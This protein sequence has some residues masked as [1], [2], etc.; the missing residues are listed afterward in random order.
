MKLTH[1]LQTLAVVLFACAS[2]WGQAVSVSNVEGTVTDQTGAVVAN[3]AVTVVNKGTGAE[4]MATTDGNG[5]Y[6][7]AGL[8]PGV[9]S[10]KIES[11]GFASQ[12]AENV[13][14]NVGTTLTLN[15]S[16]KPAAAA[17]TVVISA[18]DAGLIETTR[19]DLGGV[20]NNREIENLPLN[21]RSLAGL[22]VLIPGARPTQS[23]D[24][25]KNRSAA[26]SVN[27]GGGRNINTTV[28]GG[29]NKDNTVGGIV[30]N[31]S[32]E[33]VQE[34]KLETQRFS[35][36]SGRS[37]GAALN[38]ITKSGSNEF[39]GSGFLFA[40][41]E[42]FNANDHISKVS[43]RPKADY[44]RQQF[45]GSFGGPI[46]KDRLFFFGVYERTRE[47][48]A[49]NVSQT[50][51]NE[52]QNAV[53]VGAKPILS[54]P[55][56]FRDNLWQVRI[57]GKLND[58][59]T[60][61][62]KWA[63]QTNN[64]LNDQANITD[65][66]S[67]NFTKNTLYQGT[68]GL[69]STIS[70]TLVNQFTFAYQYW[71]NLIDSNNFAP[72]LAF[73]GAG[74]T[75][76]TNPNI[77]QQSIQKK[78]QLKEDMFLTAGSHGLK[79]GID[80]VAI[81]K[82]GGF[83]RTPPTPNLTFLDNPSV[84]VT[85]KTK[86]PQGFATP[87]AVSVLT[88]AS[89]DPNFDYHNTS[90]FSTYFQDDWKARPNLTLNLGVR[91]DL[92]I[93]FLPPLLNNRTY[94]ILKQINHPITR[95]ALGN[96][97]NNV[98]P[99]VGFAWDIKG[100]SKNVIRG[101]YGIYY[102]QVFQNI[103]L[104]AQQ[105]TNDT[106]F[107][108]VLSLT[109]TGATPQTNNDP[110]LR[111]FRYGIDPIVVPPAATVLANGAT[112]RILHPDDAM[113]YTQQW[114]IGYSRQLN[115]DYAV[116]VDYVHIL[117]LH[118]YL[119]HR[120]NPIVPGNTVVNINGQTVNNARLLAAD[121]VRAG[122]PANR[123]ADI[124]S[125][126]SIGRSRYDGL[127]IVL[128]RRFTSR[129][130]FQ[131]SYVLSRSIAYAGAANT[132]A[133][134]GFGGLAQDENRI[135]D[136]S[137]LGPTSNDERHRFVFSGVFDLPWGFQVSPILQA[138]SPRAY[139]LIQGTD[140]NGDGINNDRYL[141]PATGQ[142]VNRGSA[143][144]GYDI[145]LDPATGAIVRGDAVSARTFTLDARV[146]KYVRFSERMKLGLFFEAFNLT[147]H[148]NFGDGFQGNA[149][150]GALFQ[151]VTGYLGNRT[152]SIPPAQGGAG[153]PFQAQFGARFSF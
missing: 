108:T 144:G 95:K 44:S 62:V 124:V 102:G 59:N 3:A 101:G 76:G 80:F 7:V 5:Y 50:V 105:Q 22:A 70:P 56:P 137:E 149:R 99:R 46:K 33:G 139:T 138:A 9:Y 42:K 78:Y 143:R 97:T 66:S 104:F 15:A 120:L 79:Y 35:A 109:S 123:L 16:L 103:P 2:V 68:F 130:T 43:N 147:N 112:G 18:S 151:T 107:A 110:F 17:E 24:P 129:Y 30:M 73:P 72:F 67:G 13:T 133:A 10:I 114:N 49:F 94:Q 12:L 21:G 11:S 134:A 51:F 150:T 140:R 40:R 47:E 19:T 32:L 38:V 27:G 136:P 126:E 48:S 69:N 6:R 100:D 41:D 53:S 60:A 128:R 25:T 125:E 61:F 148:V 58:K 113:P 20:V 57:D 145:K 91:Y 71:N 29:D 122:L 86:Y 64:A 52:L 127:N 1:L 63:E 81:P 131:A 83:F 88:A 75:F 121:F 135:L 92:D 82:L 153:S 34:Y 36:A 117:G 28:D 116:E 111:T 115:K 54:V 118:E 152:A 65:E 84:I 4:R 37:E 141:D 132:G 96:D 119:R 77:P 90:M 26:F 85:D 55:T 142:V 39:H 23:F 106:V 89:G 74:V 31:F 45:G 93:N 87:G 146:S 8:V 14:L 98:A